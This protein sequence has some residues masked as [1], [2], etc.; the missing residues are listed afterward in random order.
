MFNSSFLGTRL[1]VLHDRA[2]YPEPHRCTRL[3]QAVAQIES[4]E[5]R[6]ESENQPQ[7]LG[8]GRIYL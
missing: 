7:I 4:K 5:K 3:S 1:F 8:Y 2:I 6:K